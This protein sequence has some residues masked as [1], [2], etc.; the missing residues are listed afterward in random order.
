[1]S[2]EDDIDVAPGCRSWLG[3]FNE[4]GGY[5]AIFHTYLEN[6]VIWSQLGQPKVDMVLF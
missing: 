4:Y 2:F 5:L 1:M 6:S 3:C